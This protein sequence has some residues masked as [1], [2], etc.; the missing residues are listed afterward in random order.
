MSAQSATGLGA[1]AAEG[2][3]AAIPSRCGRTRARGAHRAGARRPAPCRVGSSSPRATIVE[4]LRD[5]RVA[6][7]VTPRAEDGGRSVGTGGRSADAAG[8]RSQDGGPRTS[9][10]CGPLAD[11]DGRASRSRRP[12]RRVND[13]AGRRAPDPGGRPGDPRVIAAG[14]A[15]RAV[16]SSHRPVRRAARAAST[17]DARGASSSARASTR[18]CSPAPARWACVIVVAALPGGSCATSR[19]PSGASASLH[20][21]PPFAVL[22]LGG[23]AAPDLS[24]VAAIRAG[25]GPQVSILVDLRPWCSRPTC[26]AAHARAGPRPHSGRRPCRARGPGGGAG[27]PAAV[28]A[29]VPQA[30]WVTI[31]GS[32]RWTSRIGDLE[33]FA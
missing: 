24:V 26:R 28:R 25:G 22:A 33:R 1:S 9:G 5:R 27:R 17:S 4:H 6:E 2:W 32:R 10:P 14:A 16:A 15:A 11:R 13:R 21:T 31:E 30:A 19:R 20:P 29:N 7:V 23:A 8:L 12:D 3:L 18:R